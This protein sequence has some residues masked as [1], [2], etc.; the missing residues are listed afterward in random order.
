M[1][2]MQLTLLCLDGREIKVELPSDKPVRAIIDAL[3]R[4][5]NL[6]ETQGTDHVKYILHDKLR[7]RDLLD[8]ETLQSAGVQ[9]NSTFRLRFE[10]VA[11][12]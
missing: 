8:S 3:K 1:A 12:M 6:P 11:G 9:E 4:K 10:A 5:L 2:S 7:G